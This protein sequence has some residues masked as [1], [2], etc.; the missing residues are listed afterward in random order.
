MGEAHH[1]RRCRPYRRHPLLSNFLPQTRAARDHQRMQLPLQQQRQQTRPPLRHAW[2]T[3][4]GAAA[5]Q[6]TVPPR[7]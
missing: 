4:E 7:Q 2:G 5:L 3:I 6:A 1:R